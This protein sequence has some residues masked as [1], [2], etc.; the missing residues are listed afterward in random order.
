M[1]KS[2]FKKQNSEFVHVLILILIWVQTSSST[3][4]RTLLPTSRVFVIQYYA[5]DQKEFYILEK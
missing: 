4:N 3:P 5:N 1:M 2:R